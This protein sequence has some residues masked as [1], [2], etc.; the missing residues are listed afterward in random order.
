MNT[1][2]EQDIRDLLTPAEVAKMLRVD[3][4]TVTRWA[5]SGKLAFIRTPGGH[6]RYDD[7]EIRSFTE[8]WSRAGQE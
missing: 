5:K 6:R 1:T 2:T 4:K 3:T 7:A 8:G